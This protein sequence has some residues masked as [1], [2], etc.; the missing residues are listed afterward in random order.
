[1]DGTILQQNQ[2]HCYNKQKDVRA[3]CWWEFLWAVTNQ[4]ICFSGLYTSS[5]F[6]NAELCIML[7]AIKVLNLRKLAHL[8]YG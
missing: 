3:G 8:F 7:D 1:M 2:I 4:T 6:K 5:D